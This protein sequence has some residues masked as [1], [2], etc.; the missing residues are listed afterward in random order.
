[1]TAAGR[2]ATLIRRLIAYSLGSVVAATSGELSFVAVYGWLAAGNVAASAAGF[3]GGAIPNYVV[4]RR[5]VWGDR[6]GRR[7][8]SETVLYWVIAL[9]SFGASVLVTDVAE[10]WARSLTDDR[11]W[12]VLFVAGAYLAVAG[13]FFVVKFVLFHFVV[14]T[15]IP[16]GP[17]DE[18]A[19]AEPSGAPTT[20]S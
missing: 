15:P 12:Q 5:W 4:N 18:G 17:A 13:G 20:T 7:G 6:R 14:F 9:A 16:T 19:P 10:D 3:V 8:R 11:S 1:V 2:R